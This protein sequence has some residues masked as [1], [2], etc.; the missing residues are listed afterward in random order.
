METGDWESDEVSM[1]SHLFKYKKAEKQI[2]IGSKKV[3]R[4]RL[5]KLLC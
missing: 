4:K 2:V 3:G 5:S 1:T